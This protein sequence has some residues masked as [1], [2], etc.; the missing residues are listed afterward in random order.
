MTIVKTMSSIGWQIE[1]QYEIP[2]QMISD[3]AE[4]YQ[5][6]AIDLDQEALERYEN[7]SDIQNDSIARQVSDGNPPV[8]YAPTVSA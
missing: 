6:E 4:R 3:V 7:S 5:R 1:T 8:S 2:S